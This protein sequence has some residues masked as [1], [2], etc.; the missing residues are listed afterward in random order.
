VPIYADDYRALLKGPGRW[1]IEAE[2]EQ[3][4]ER[5]TEGPDR[6]LQLSTAKE[7]IIIQ[8]NPALSRKWHYFNDW[9]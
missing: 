4:I 8:D 6:V 3:V 1:Q 9:S 5:N 2:M 7:N